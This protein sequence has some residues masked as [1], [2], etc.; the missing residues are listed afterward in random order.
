MIKNILV[1]GGAG[2]LGTVLCEKLLDKGFAVVCL[3]RLWFGK[4]PIRHLR[5]NPHFSLVQADILDMDAHSNIFTDIGAV[6]HLAGLSDDTSADLDRELTRAVNYEGSLN[7]ARRAKACGVK[8]FLFASTCSVYGANG[9]SMVNEASPLQ[10]LSWYARL[11]A[12][13]EKEILALA[14]SDFS[15]AALRLATL[16]G[17]SPRM[18][19]DLAVNRMALHACAAKTIS[20]FGEGTQWRPFLHVADAADA[21]V[22]CLNLPDE[23]LSGRTYNLGATTGNYRIMDVARLI[24]EH[25]QDACIS[26]VPEAPDRR[27]YRVDFETIARQNWHPEYTIE[28][29]LPELLAAIRSTSDPGD[30]RYYNLDTMQTMLQTPAIE[31]GVPVRTTALP[32]CVPFIGPEEEAE[33]LAVLRSGWLTRGPR[34]TALEDRMKNF[35]GCGHAICVN[36]CTAAL[37]VSLAALGIGNGDEV[38]TSPVTWPSTAN[39]IVH[40]G[41]TPVF[42]DIDP[43]TLNIDAREI[44]QKITARTRAVIPVHMAGRPCAMDDIHALAK[45]HGLFVIED[46]A[47]AVGAVYKGRK[48]GTLSDTTCFSFYPIKNM[49]TGEGGLVATDSDDLAKRIKIY[50]LH[51]IDTD[52]W[53]RREHGSQALGNVVFPGFKYNMSDIQAAIGLPQLD[54]LEW[55]IEQRKSISE[56]YDAAFAGL[57]AIS[58]PRAIDGIQEAYHLYIIILN[59]EKL[60]IDRDQF[61]K[62]LLM[63][64]IHTG[65]HFRPLHQQLYYRDRFGFKKEDFPHAAYIGDRIV[66]LPLYPKM[67]GRD[68]D[69]VIQGVTRL[70]HFYQKK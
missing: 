37:H 20:V 44:E 46:A 33:V 55:A 7:L 17:V 57:P 2:Y 22:H 38:I 39:V 68:V 25:V 18:R 26:M 31:N 59:I 67:T 42:A 10:P 16:Y 66:S 62:A 32:L 29:S 28:K 24:Q 70:I 4:G 27:S 45:R 40:T 5:D 43:A 65:V 36:S 69:T 60:T 49:T 34:T 56:R 13:A 12:D 52:A 9:D 14:D 11:K 61:R 54:R 53:Q 19:F 47:H 15:P 41:A 21:F 64:N 3:D 23:A 1:T 48:I 63:E 8:K 30:A 50:G 51:G 58:L 35:L 6:I